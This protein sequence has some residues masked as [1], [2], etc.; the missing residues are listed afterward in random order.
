M[1]SLE[2]A[3]KQQAFS[4]E[5][6]KAKINI[7]YTA[8]WLYNKISCT[9]KPYGL[10]QEQYNVLRILLRNLE[11]GVCQKDIVARMIAPRSNVTLLVKK[12]Q[13][14]QLI[15]VTQSSKDKREYVIRITQEGLNLLNTLDPVMEKHNQMLATITTE[16]S[17][18]LNELLDKLRG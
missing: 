6:V 13:S 18:I 12:L 9:L 15:S 1:P 16:E 2:N 10:T 17:A 4:S 3:L 5:Q 11:N 14:K 7:L 8:N